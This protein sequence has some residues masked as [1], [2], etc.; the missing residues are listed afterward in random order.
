MHMNIPHLNRK[1]TGIHHFIISMSVKIPTT[2]KESSKNVERKAA[3]WMVIQREDI[4]E[5]YA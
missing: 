1:I 2:M 3:K 5:L 4:V